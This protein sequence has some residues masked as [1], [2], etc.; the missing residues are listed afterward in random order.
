VNLP[1][2]SHTRLLRARTL[3]G[4]IA[5]D[6]GRYRRALATDGAAYL[7]LCNRHERLEAA[8]DG[9]GYRCD[10]Q[11]TS[12]LHAPEHLP[13]L[14]LRLLRRALADHPVER[15]VAPRRPSAS[16]EITFLIGHRG[17]A[18]LP[19]LRATLESI[20][21]QRDV[22]LE[23]LVIEQDAAP[24]IRAELPD[25][26]RHV[27]TPPPISDMPYCRAWAFNVGARHARGRILVLHDN[28]MLVPAD[29]AREI[30][31]RV[32]DRFEVVNL[33]RFIF[34]LG[35]EHSRAVAGGTAPL[36]D[37]IASGSLTPAG[38]PAAVCLAAEAARLA[39][40]LLEDGADICWPPQASATLRAA[41]RWLSRVALLHRAGAPRI[42]R[43]QHHH[44]LLTRAA[45]R[46][47]ASPI[48][49]TRFALRVPHARD[50]PRALPGLRC[51][52][53]LNRPSLTVRSPLDR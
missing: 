26:V 27:H 39:T 36:V 24:N 34:Y 9:C 12:N 3:L 18:R 14:G 19:H 50:L 10:W 47:L 30:L 21:G 49:M 4:V 25:W 29:Y 8:P 53:V 2:A 40:H 45:P 1:I 5:R 33:K 17:M 11:W 20:A 22:G 46:P 32:D 52:H 37:S 42:L 7:A 31:R 51:S 44:D 13:A 23:C 41:G 35:A 16:P 15:L 6:L 48:S 43:L 38:Q 28:D